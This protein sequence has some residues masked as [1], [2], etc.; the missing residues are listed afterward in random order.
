VRGSTNTVGDAVTSYNTTTRVQTIGPDVVAAAGGLLASFTNGAASGTNLS[1]SVFSNGLIKT[2]G[3]AFTPAGTSAVLSAAGTLTNGFWNR[4]EGT[5]W[6]ISQGYGTG[7]GISAGTATNIFSAMA[8]LTYWTTNTI[9]ITNTLD[10]AITGL[11]A[12]RIMVDEMRMFL[13]LTNGSPLSKRAKLDM[14]HNS[15]RRGTDICYRDTNQLYYSVLTTVAGVAGTWTNVV[16]DA[17]GSVVGDLYYKAI[18]NTTTSDYQR[19]DSATAT[20]MTWETP[21]SNQWDSAT[22]TLISHVNQYSC[23]PYYDATGASS[24]WF[25]LTFPAGYTGTLST[26]LNYGR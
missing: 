5:N 12:N 20:V 6:V 2:V 26:V 13:S 10:F 15:T 14:F 9:T 16:A 19:L 7:S 24:M 22:N 3:T 1:G 17:S 11:V 18:A 25:R 8:E 21:D 23:F 4:T